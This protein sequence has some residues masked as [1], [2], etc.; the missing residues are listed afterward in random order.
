M[1]NSVPC[2]ACHSVHKGFNHLYPWKNPEVNQMCAACHN[3]VWAAFQEPFTHN[4]QALPNLQLNLTFYGLTNSNP[5][6][7]NRRSPYEPSNL[8]RLELAAEWRATSQ[9]LC[10]IHTGTIDSQPILCNTEHVS[11]CH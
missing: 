10:R 8:G 6:P 3:N 4:Y 11:A 1:K 9:H 7:F 2:T 5:N